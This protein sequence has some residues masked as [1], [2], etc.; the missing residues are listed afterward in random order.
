MANQDEQNRAMAMMLNFS[1]DQ[2]RMLNIVLSTLLSAII[3]RQPNLKT[4]LVAVIDRTPAADEDTARI[5]EMARQF[6]ESIP[7]WVN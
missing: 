1:F 5:A 4:E 2:V 3:A 7:A 6:I